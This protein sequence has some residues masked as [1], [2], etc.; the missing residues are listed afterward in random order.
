MEV[1]IRYD[2]FSFGSIRIDGITYEH[3]VAIG[4]G[5]VCR[6]S[7]EASPRKLAIS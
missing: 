2:R 5:P 6:R 3:D 7:P 1:L 4:E